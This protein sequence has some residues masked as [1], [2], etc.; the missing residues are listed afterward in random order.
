[1]DE[2]GWGNT[3]LVIGEG[4]NKKVM[5]NDDEKFDDSM[6]PLKK[7]SGESTY[8]RS[9]WNL[10]LNLF[11]EYEAEAWETGSRHSDETGYEGKP[12]SQSHSRIP[13]SRGES[14]PS[15][16]YHQASQ[17]GDYYRDTNAM[18]NGSNPNLRLGS[19]ASHSNLSHHISQ[20]LAPQ[21]P[22]MGL[23]GGPGSFH[24]SD[25]GLMPTN[26]LPVGYQNP[27]SVYGMPLAPQNTMMGNVYTAGGG[28]Q[29]QSGSFGGVPPSIPVLQ[30]RPISTFSLATT[31]NPFAGPSLNPNPSDDELFGAL[32]SYLS[33][34]DLMTVT[35]KYAECSNV[36]VTKLN[37]FIYSGLHV[38][39]SWVDSRRQT[40]ILAKI[41]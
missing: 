27:G 20:N 16:S 17:A 37:F 35:K 26:M 40:S 12:H 25:N 14:P 19:Q 22:F 36:I 4:S 5:M 41:F 15:R 10:V 33:T 3:R 39:R 32:R 28:S 18:N 9:P 7:F 2:F 21:L 34:Q 11:P 23:G 8:C 1:M 24:G 13:Q 6:I 30:Q 31:V 29:S 38:K